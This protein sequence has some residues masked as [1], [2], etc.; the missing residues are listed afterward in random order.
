MTGA[1]SFLKPALHWLF[2]G[3][4]RFETGLLTGPK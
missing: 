3:G 1:F 2:P 4:H